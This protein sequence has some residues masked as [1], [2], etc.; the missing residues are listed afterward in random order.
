LILAGIILT[1]LVAGGAWLLCRYWRR[2]QGQYARLLA[3]IDTIDGNFSLWD[4]NERLIAFNENF[5]NENKTVAG[6][7]RPGVA[8][9]DYI[10]ARVDGGLLPG[11][12]G[13]REEWIER[14]LRGFRVPGDAIEMELPDGR[15]HLVNSSRTASGDTL[16]FGIDV[17]ASVLARQEVEKSEARFQ[18]MAMAAAD[19]FWETDAEHRFTYLSD[20]I[21]RM[22]GERSADLLGKRRSDLAP[23]RIA[24]PAWDEHLA[25]LDRHD[26]FRDFTFRRQFD[27]GRVAWF[28]ISGLPRFDADGTFLDYRGVGRDVTELVLAREA[29]ERSEAKFRDFAKAASDAFWEMDADLRFTSTTLRPAEYWAPKDIL[30]KA[31]WDLVG[32]D[33]Q[34][35]TF[36]R[37]HKEMLER[38]QPFRDFVYQ[39]RDRSGV[40]RQLHVS[41]RPVFAEDGTFVGYRGMAND[42]TELYHS[43]LALRE[44]QQR[45]QSIVDN[46]SSGIALLD[47]DFRVRMVNR[48]YARMHGRSAS[49]LEGHI[50]Y[51]HVADSDPAAFEALLRE[52]AATGNTVVQ[53]AHGQRDGG[54]TFDRIVTAFPIRSDSG[55]I[56]GL[57]TIVTDVSSLKEAEERLRQAQKMEAV[58]QLTGGVAHDFNNLLAVI[59]GNAELLGEQVGMANALVTAIL[60]AAERGAELTG[61]LLAFSRQQPLRRRPF[62]LAEL[63]T[64]LNGLLRRTLGPTIVIETPMAPDLW[65]VLADAGQ[66]ENALLNLVLNARDAM[67]SG[68]RVTIEATN[69]TLDKADA[70][71]AEDIEPGNYIALSVSDEGT[72]MTLD[73]LARAYEPFFT[74]KDVGRGSGLGLSMVYGFARQS[75]GHVTIHSEPGHGTIVRL[76]LPRAPLPA[77]RTPAALPDGEVPLGAGKVILV[78]EDQPEVRDLTARMLATLGY[79]TETAIDATAAR[80]ILQSGTPVDLVLSDVVLPGGMSGPEFAHEVCS[81]RPEMKILLCP[82]IRTT[83]SA[84]PRRPRT[85]R[86]WP[87]PSAAR[88]WHA[89]SPHGS[90]GADRGSGGHIPPLP[91]PI[92]LPRRPPSAS[93]RRRCRASASRAAPRRYAGRASG[94]ASDAAAC[95][96]RAPARSAS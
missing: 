6:V 48:A 73:V 15:W 54:G 62:D 24:D 26:A 22:T 20:N 61:R 32:A 46:S 9:A 71:V 52:V 40:L 56:T 96:P 88:T 34:R 38:H 42:T 12:L 28:N 5:S 67:P 65:P 93:R 58:G 89:P 92:I 37:Q 13:R 25:T 53:E 79:R 19:W 91:F 17:T 83:R 7:V 51:E 59:S 55:A 68:G 47:L 45:L 84:T 74:T 4:R 66:V 64:G 81:A 36:W 69:V 85:G 86:S 44:N 94:M 33:P 23:A 75:G 1:V 57:G 78:I 90:P 21:E 49:N 76:Y 41:G 50:I 30:G 80:A 43:E 60:H 10:A 77:E 29:L 31:R 11:A 35:D 63:V 27:S 39:F 72:G 70:E 87:N 95:R 16:V 3:A 14:R 8:F 2:D 82:A 18:D